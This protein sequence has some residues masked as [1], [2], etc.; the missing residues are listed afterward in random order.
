[1]Q[2][3]EIMLPLLSQLLLPLIE[4][5]RVGDGNCH[6]GHREQYDHDHHDHSHDHDDR[7]ASFARRRQFCRRSVSGIHSGQEPIHYGDIFMQQVDEDILRGL[8]R[9][10][11]RGPPQRSNQNPGRGSRYRLLD[12][13][14]D[15]DE[16]LTEEELVQHITA[17]IR[18]ATKDTVNLFLELTIR[19]KNRFR[20]Q[21]L[22]ISF[23][24]CR[25]SHVF[26]SLYD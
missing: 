5:T 21:S 4:P 14:P 17:G 26:S 2:I 16:D 1:M 20:L 19:I 18:K 15:L 25:K 3:F 13:T 10:V 23:L 9:T 8:R 6:D 24:L 22:N 11:T 12:P 7:I